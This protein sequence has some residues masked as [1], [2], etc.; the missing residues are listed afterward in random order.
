MVLGN[1]LATG[2]NNNARGEILLY[3]RGV[4]VIWSI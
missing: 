4:L 2:T 3:G 1:N